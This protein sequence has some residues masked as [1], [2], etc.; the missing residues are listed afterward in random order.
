MGTAHPL[1]LSLAER[2][3]Q[4]TSGTPLSS[5]ICYDSVLRSL[6][7]ADILDLL[8]HLRLN[9]DGV[10]HM[11]TP[12]PPRSDVS[13]CLLSVPLS[14]SLSKS[15]TLHFQEGP[16]FSRAAPC[17]WSSLTN[18]KILCLRGNCFPGSSLMLHDSTSLVDTNSQWSWLQRSLS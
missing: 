14:C 8:L 10:L 7:N 6:G 16:C 1:S 12:V 17:V 15:L 9:R 5:L 18:L 2:A 13:H 11:C 3:L 4:V